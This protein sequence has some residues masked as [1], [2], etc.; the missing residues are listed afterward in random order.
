MCREF[1]WQAY[2]MEF[3]SLGRWWRK[4]REID[5]VG[6]NEGTREILFVECK[7]QDRVPAEKVLRSLREKALR[8]DWY[9]K[10]RKERY[11]IIARS[12]QR[13]GRLPALRC[14]GP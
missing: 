2:P 11:C 3:T 14:P 1:L 5:L 6:I 7:W 10:K 8:V 12:V 4:Q 9:H 13:Q